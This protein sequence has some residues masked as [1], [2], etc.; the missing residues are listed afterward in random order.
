MLSFRIAAADLIIGATCAGCGCPAITVC[1]DCIPEFLPKPCA[2]WP[3]P[4]P[5][6]L[7]APTKITPVAS[8]IHS[9]PLR[10]ALAQYKEE[11]QFGLLR[12][13]SHML[14][15]SICLTAPPD[16]ALA[17]VPIPSSRLTSMKRGQDVV[18]ELAK[19][20]AAALRGIGLDCRVSRPLRHARRVS[21][22]S[23]LNAIERS[24]NMAG[25]FAV[26]STTHLEGRSVVL[27]DDIITTG[28]TVCEAV[29]VLGEAGFRPAGIA[30]IAATK[31]YS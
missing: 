7:I 11:G 19:A 3:K 25:S 20:S 2:A 6:A 18:A 23:G 15:A 10:A 13:L 17:L 24:L 22:Q 12:L 16:A 14:A 29:R 28:A 26:G 21:D 31:R 27:V 8:G 5:E 9:G 1:D 4:I 30:V